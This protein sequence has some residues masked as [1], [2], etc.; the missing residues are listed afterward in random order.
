MNWDAIGAVGEIIGAIAVVVS[1]G[2]LGVQIRV[3]NR[4]SRMA[5][6]HDVLEGFRTE[7]AAF[8]KVELAELLGK[9]TKDFEA[10]SETERIQFIA[11]IQGPFRL[12]EEA[13][14]QHRGNRLSLAMWEGIHAQMRDFSAPPGCQKVW[15]LRRHTYSEEFRTYVDNV[16]PGSFRTD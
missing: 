3:Q 12:W 10:L 13:Y 6:V 5:S 14:H 4:E 2:Y 9:G 7:I 8:R 1:L 15:A 11:M 16:E